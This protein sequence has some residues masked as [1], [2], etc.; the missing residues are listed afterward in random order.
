MIS[1]LVII[2]E[3]KIPFPRDIPEDFRVTMLRNRPN[4]YGVLRSK[5]TDLLHNIENN[6]HVD[7]YSTLK[8]KLTL[9]ASSQL[10][11]NLLLRKN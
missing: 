5:G 4:P 1:C 6:T 8:I 11:G 2:Q 9:F 3:Y 10:L 7:L